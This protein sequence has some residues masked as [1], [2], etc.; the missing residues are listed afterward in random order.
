MKLKKFQVEEILSFVKSFCLLF[1]GF[2]WYISFW[3]YFEPLWGITCYF[4]L[5]S[6][7]VLGSTHIVEQLSFS[8][9][10][11]ILTFEFDSILW[12]FFTFWGPNGLFL[13]LW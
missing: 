2:F 6:K 3:G 1:S 9:L 5:R 4:G 11:S 7:T 12:L 8:M 10:C 13:G